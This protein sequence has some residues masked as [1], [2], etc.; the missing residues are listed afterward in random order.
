MQSRLKPKTTADTT[1]SRLSGLPRFLAAWVRLLGLSPWEWNL[2]LHLWF[3]PA[4]RP[5]EWKRDY[6]GSYGLPLRVPG[7][8]DAWDRPTTSQSLGSSIAS[9]PSSA[10]IS[11]D[12][13][14][15]PSFLDCPW[16][17]HGFQP[18]KQGLSSNRNG[19]FPAVGS[20]MGGR[21]SACSALYSTLA[22]GN[23]CP[24]VSFQ[25]NERYLEIET[26]GNCTLCHM[27]D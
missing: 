16:Y 13:T 27:H 10:L 11:S 7:A 23:L 8:R 25:K 9:W 12:H 5:I 15:P 1:S 17:G 20:R 21:D 6:A 14:P 22:V 4:C 3:G 26:T 2:M 24:C 19:G 18:Y